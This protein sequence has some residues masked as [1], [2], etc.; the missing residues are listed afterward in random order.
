MRGGQEVCEPEVMA[1]RGRSGLG[2]EDGGRCEPAVGMGGRGTVELSLGTVAAVEAS[3]LCRT[4]FLACGLVREKPLSGM[5]R[6][7][8]SNG[9]MD[10]VP[11]LDCRKSGYS[12]GSALCSAGQTPGECQGLR[13]ALLPQ[14]DP[15]L[16]T[17]KSNLSPRKMQIFVIEGE[18]S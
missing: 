15:G 18:G 5:G 6:A 14:G 11:D 7:I 13:S 9:R 12:S 8:L 1:A 16:I 17:T 2:R 3:T 4:P 10:Q